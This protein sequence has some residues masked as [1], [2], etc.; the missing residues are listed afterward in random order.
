MGYEAGFSF[1]ERGFNCACVRVS[2]FG[3]S[4]LLARES[5]LAGVCRLN[6]L[7]S[8]QLMW[9]PAGRDL[10]HLSNQDT[11]LIRTPLQSGHL[12]SL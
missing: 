3:I 2:R 10:G 12:P 11:S 8:L 7:A 1:T 9:L 4:C 6:G 5:G